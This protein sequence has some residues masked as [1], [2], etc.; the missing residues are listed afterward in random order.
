MLRRHWL[1]EI[2]LG[3]QG[4]QGDLVPLKDPPNGA[5]IARNVLKKISCYLRVS[6]ALDSE[7]KEQFLGICR[8]LTHGDM[9]TRTF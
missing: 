9:N 6:L 8:M 3:L 7:R 5:L 1:R 4:A 2:K